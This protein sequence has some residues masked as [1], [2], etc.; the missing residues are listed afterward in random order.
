MKS[1]RNIENIGERMAAKRNDEAKRR[2]KK[3]RRKCGE[4]ENGHIEEE[5]K[6][7]ENIEN[8]AWSEKLMAWKAKNKSKKMK[9]MWKNNENEI[10]WINERSEKFVA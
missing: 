6:R 1:W 5:E 2:K 10:I 9:G 7:N 3:Y 4:S 8:Q